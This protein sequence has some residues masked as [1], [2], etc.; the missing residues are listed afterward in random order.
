[1]AADPSA[2]PSEQRA[3]YAEA[4][5]RFDLRVLT[6]SRVV[7]MAGAL[8]I[9]AGSQTGWFAAGDE[10]FKAS[11][12]IKP[13]EWFALVGIPCAVVLFVPRRRWALRLADAVA[14]VPALAIGWA[15]TRDLPARLP[16]STDVARDLYWG[17]WLSA[18][19]VIL[20]VLGSLAA[21]VIHE[22]IEASAVKRCPD[23]AEEVLRE[24]RV[25]KHC[26]H[27][28]VWT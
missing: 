9:L 22:R 19:G 6:V 1:M 2:L 24:A 21:T 23:C 18:G 26:G 4:M 20:A 8:A 28:F 7:A 15:L 5:R 25:C 16:D 17:V 11:E 14:I 27:R 3:A 12:A 10:A 13:A